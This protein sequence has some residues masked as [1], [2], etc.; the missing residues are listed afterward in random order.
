MM[1]DKTEAAQ[2]KSQACL[3]VQQYRLHL[4][5]DKHS[6]GLS[7]YLHGYTGLTPDVKA[8]M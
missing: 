5:S 3:C 4:V 8:N 2:R 7:L 6:A 1:C